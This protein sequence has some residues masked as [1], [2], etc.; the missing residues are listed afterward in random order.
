MFKTIGSIA[1]F[2]SII[3]THS[4]C[5]NY[6]V[7]LNDRQLYTPAPLIAKIAAQ[8]TGLRSCLF[9]TIED[10]QLRDPD[11]L[12]ALGCSSAG[13]SD[14]QGLNQFPNLTQLHLPKNNISDI[15]VLYKL[16]KLE[17]VNLSDNPI[18]NL[19]PLLGLLAL[20]EVDMSNT[21]VSCKKLAALKKVVKQVQ[22]PSC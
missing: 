14:L 21:N 10:Q 12:T 11:K 17:S 15:E 5:S 16:P 7:S 6:E 4:G 13:I 22:G 8:D 2:T 1:L 20:K 3:M 19:Q 9:Q 18:S